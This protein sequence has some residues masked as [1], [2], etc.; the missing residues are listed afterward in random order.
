MSAYQ[1]EPLDNVRDQIRLIRLLPQLYERRA[2]QCEIATYNLSEAPIYRAVSYEWGDPEPL[3][4]LRIGSSQVLY[5]RQ[6]LWLFLETLRETEE[7]N[8]L[9]WIDQICIDQGHV[10]E[11]THQVQL[12][13]K[14]YSKADCVLAWLGSSTGV[15]TDILPAIEKHTVYRDDDSANSFLGFGDDCETDP[16]AACSFRADELAQIC[17]WFHVVEP[18]TLLDISEVSY[19]TRL[20]IVQENVL[21]QNV[22]YFLGSECF[23]RF[24]LND[25][26][27]RLIDI[28][29]SLGESF[30]T[31]LLTALTDSESLC[32][33]QNFDQVIQKF[34]SS[35]LKC[36]VPHDLVF[37]LQGMV[38]EAER[39]PIDY[40][41]PT[42][43]IFA[44]ILD[45]VIC[46]PTLIQSMEGHLSSIGGPLWLNLGT[47]WS[48][49]GASPRWCI[50]LDVGSGKPSAWQMFCDNIYSF[51]K[52]LNFLEKGG[53]VKSK[54]TAAELFCITRA[55]VIHTSGSYRRFLK[56]R[57]FH[58]LKPSEDNQYH[59]DTINSL[60][61]A[62]LPG[63]LI[64][65]TGSAELES[66]NYLPIPWIIMLE[67][68]WD[69]ED[70]DD[71]VEEECHKLLDSY[72]KDERRSS[73]SLT[74]ADNSA[75]TKVTE[76]CDGT[77]RS[78][79]RTS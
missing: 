47:L 22:I 2:I 44:T 70:E 51:L 68:G 53:L 3:R 13:G 69:P 42:W 4:E 78:W 15:R 75:Q 41:Q 43:A 64:D 27:E 23:D 32:V 54:R 16:C 66:A 57:E 76:N 18:R 17:P 31:R 62:S 46:S 1:H 40:L 49:L 9:L 12:M 48:K 11:R 34:G 8:S 60:P 28:E 26:F 38:K 21:A 72:D 55:M 33:D 71:Y 20:W 25:Y 24:D 50:W 36:T 61:K 79:T 58:G 6:N 37:G 30:H 65:I 59:I 14:I 67:P 74:E 52:C 39:V 63:W 19:W 29:P 73:N 77:K 7:N 5:V 56:T 10:E 45:L 35:T